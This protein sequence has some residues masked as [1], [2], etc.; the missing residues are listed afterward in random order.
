M[1]CQRNASPYSACF[2]SRSCARFSPTTV[3][4][5][6]G[7]RRHVGERDVL[8]RRDDRHVRRRP[9]ACTRASRSRIAAQATA[10][11]TPWTPRA[12]PVAA[13]REEELRVVS[14]C[15]GRPAR[16]RSTPARAQRALGRRPEVED[17]VARQVGVE[18]R[19][20]LRRRPRSSTARSPARRPPPSARRRAPRRR[21]RRRPPRAR[22]SPRAATASARG[23]VGARDRD[24]QAVGG[25]ARASAARA[26]RSRARRPARRARPGA[27]RCTVGVCTLPVEREP[28]R[29]RGRAPRTRRRRFSATRSGSSP[30]PRV[31]LSDAY[32]PSLT[33]PTRVVNATT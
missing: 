24:R 25:R 9:R 5:G 4:A 3:D 19:R 20:H 22:A 23:A 8:R 21:P 33:P 28:R 15:R 1:K 18:A 11:I 7:E 17:A 12:R 31:R 27:A 2:A 29:R 26:R 10:P 14:A 6:L 13:V 32:G 30:V 16:P